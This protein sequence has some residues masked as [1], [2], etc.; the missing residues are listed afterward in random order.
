MCPVVSSFCF[1]AATVMSDS[2]KLDSGGS[3]NH[4]G[5]TQLASISAHI[6][7]TDRAHCP[8]A[9][10]TV[11]LTAPFPSWKWV[12]LQLLGINW[13]TLALL[14][15]VLAVSSGIN[16]QL[17]DM[18]AQGINSQKQ[19]D[20]LQLLMAQ[21]EVNIARWNPSTKIASPSMARSTTPS[22]WG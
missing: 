8:H 11:N 1:V 7:S 10:V 13:A 12:R 14:V 2:E 20:K 9:E 15:A 5:T 6:P 19:I 4:V 22:T 3:S 17:D 21:S 16:K 18:R